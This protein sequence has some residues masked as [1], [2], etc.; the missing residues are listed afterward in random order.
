MAYCI[1]YKRQVVRESLSCKSCAPQICRT[2]NSTPRL[3]YHSKKQ[4][5]RRK[6]NNELTQL[7]SQKYRF[8]R[9]ECLVGWHILENDF[10]ER[11]SSTAAISP[12]KTG[13]HHAA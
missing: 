4:Y 11:G 8:E 10:Q 5:I 12:A 13:N 7:E 6:F 9:L 2:E 3:A 1:Q